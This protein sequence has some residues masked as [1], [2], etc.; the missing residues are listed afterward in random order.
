MKKKIITISFISF[1]SIVLWVFVALSQEFITTVEIPISF[2]ELPKNYSVGSSSTDQIFFKIKGKGWEL[3]KLFL[4]SREEFLISTH[5]RI[6]KYKN[7]L[8]DFLDINPWLNSNF[9]VLEISPTQ[10]EYEVEKVNSKRV[11]IYRN[12]S[13]EFKQGFAATSAVKITPEFIELYGPSS[14]LQNI[15]SVK[16]ESKIYQNI[17][18]NFSEQLQLADIQGVIFSVTKCNVEF[19]VQKIVDKKI[20]SVPVELRNVPESKD[21]TLFPG[22]VDIVLR[23]GINK[24]GKITS[25]SIKAFVNYWKALKS[26]EG[27]VEPEIILPEFVTLIAVEPKKIEYIIKQ[28]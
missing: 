10:I 22:K 27:F 7:E 9:Q 15:D 4:G 16:T 21:L 2:S 23:G 25:D 14:I 6:G 26:N 20:E 12:F 5:R 28:Y 13:I 18:E 24:L 8:R 11:K 1:L 3:A 19:E 17:N